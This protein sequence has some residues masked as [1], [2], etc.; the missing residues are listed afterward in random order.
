MQ[1]LRPAKLSELWQIW[2]LLHNET[3]N[4]PFAVRANLTLEGLAY[5]LFCL[6]ERIL[7]YETDEKISGMVVIF[8]GRLGHLIVKSQNRGH[9]VAS[10]LLCYGEMKAQLLGWNQ[11]TILTDKSMLQFYSKRGYE[12]TTRRM[13]VKKLA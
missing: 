9:G 8:G 4:Q 10:Q 11:I 13:M 1:T 3:K 2:S 7:V 6:T 12:R 5:F